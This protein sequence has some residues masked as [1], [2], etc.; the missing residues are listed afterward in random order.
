MVQVASRRKRFTQPKRRRNSAAAAAAEVPLE[1]EHEPC[2]AT[3]RRW[4][5][6]AGLREIAALSKPQH[7]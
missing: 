4:F 7:N 1:P 5:G 3:V 2:D 6:S